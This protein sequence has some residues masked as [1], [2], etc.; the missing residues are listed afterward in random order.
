MPVYEYRCPK[1]GNEF[2]VMRPISKADEPAL[3]P[4]CG[5]SGEKL[6]SPF[7]SK[8]GFYV[9]APRKPPFRK[10]EGETAK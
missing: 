2:E 5:S 9:R 10:R 8:A 7:A 3:C 6:M 4:K 1:C